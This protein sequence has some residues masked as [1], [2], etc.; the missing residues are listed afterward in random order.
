MKAAYSPHADSLARQVIDHLTTHG[1]S[2]N[3]AEVKEV[4]GATNPS[5]ALRKAIDAALLAVEKVGTQ[6]VYSLPEPGE[7]PAADPEGKLQIALHDDGDVSVV[8]GSPT[9]DGGIMYNKAQIEQLMRRV[10]L[11]HCVIGAAGSVA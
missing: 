4:F 11:P 3:S 10:M 7:D 8:G 5:S 9:V 2:L 6:Y 1:G